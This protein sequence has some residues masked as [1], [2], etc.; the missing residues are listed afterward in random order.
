MIGWG[1]GCS[2]AGISDAAVPAAAPDTELDSTRIGTKALRG[3]SS[4]PLLRARDGVCC[5]NEAL[6]CGRR[7]VCRKLLRTGRGCGKLAAVT[8]GTNDGL[9]CIISADDEQPKSLSHCGQEFHVIAKKAKKL[10]KE[11]EITLVCERKLKSNFFLAMTCFVFGADSALYR[12]CPYL[13][14][15]EKAR[16]ARWI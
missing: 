5:T 14:R 2:P 1:V 15:P 12:T 6:G 7:D 3:V 11:I 13:R 9:A 10:C 8:I 16:G 4:A